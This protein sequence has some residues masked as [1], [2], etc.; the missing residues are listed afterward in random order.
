MSYQ[1]IQNL[2][3]QDYGCIK[4]AS[5]A[6]SPLHALIG[7]NDSGKSTTLRALRVVADCA[8]AEPSPRGSR[9]QRFDPMLGPKTRL[10]V[11]YSD[12]LEIATHILGNPAEI[13]VVFGK[14][15]GP[16][17]EGRC[18]WETRGEILTQVLIESG[19][20]P[21]LEALRK[22][23]TPATMV[24]FDPNALR[25]TARQLFSA[26][27][28]QFLDETGMG[29]SSVYQAINS[30][31]VDA[32]VAIRDKVKILFPTV[33]NILVPSVEG[34]AVVLQAKLTDDTL[35]PAEALSEGLLYFLGYVALQYV[36]GSKLFLVEE[37][38]NG[39]HPA[40]IAEVMS[41]L[42]E[43]SKTSQVIIATH[44]PLVVN[45]LHGNEVSIV[46]RD[47]EKGTQVKLLKD[48]PDFEEASKVYQPGEYWVSYCDGN[49]EEP[50]LTGRPRP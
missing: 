7:P 11:G 8:A 1:P 49:Q 15:Q 44:S 4:Q 16:K 14:K 48:V 27:P 17:Y 19:G 2:E 31:D 25:R 5:F 32:F 9:P 41:I 22:R 29:L 43:I 13:H 50:L 6:L 34:G 47:P 42:R 24:R 40:R 3:I 36:A 39:L 20:L 35:V 28:I 37:P 33:Q 30:R 45:E 10:G 26:E 46:T 23:I 21:T 12:E 38:E 18:T